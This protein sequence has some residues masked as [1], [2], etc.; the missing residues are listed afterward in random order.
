DGRADQY[1]L[2]ATVYELLSGRPP[3]ERRTQPGPP[4][5]T[6]ATEPPELCRI[7]PSI[8]EALTSAVHRGLS[9]DP[10][11]RFPDCTTFA[12]AVVSAAHQPGPTALAAYP[13]AAVTPASEFGQRRPL[14]AIP[15]PDHPVGSQTNRAALGLACS[16]LIVVVGA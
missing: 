15:T 14:L 3:F 12:R 10:E 5:Q 13:P 7:C 1:A 11:H 2:A 9:R 8:S 4:I 6:S 16:A